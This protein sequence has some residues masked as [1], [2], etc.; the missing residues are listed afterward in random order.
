MN[1]LISFI[2]LV[3]GIA[4]TVVLFIYQFRFGYKA[5]RTMAIWGFALIAYAGYRGLY[6]LSDS[7]AFVYWGALGSGAFLVLVGLITFLLIEAPRL[8]GQLR[9][10]DEST[11]H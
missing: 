5:Q 9:E 8:Q 11:A 1:Q 6:P 2:L 3:A 10:R 7:L 4:L